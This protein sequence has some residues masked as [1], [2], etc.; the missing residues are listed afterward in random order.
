MA[1]RNQWEQFA[2]NFNTFYDLTGKV[3][4]GMENRKIMDDEVTEGY[5]NEDGL[6]G[7]HRG[8]K[9]FRYG[10]EVYDKQITPEKLRGLRNQ[11]LINVMSKYGDSKGAMEL[12]QSQAT[13]DATT[14]S[15][16]AQVKQNELFA[17]TFDER[18]KSFGLGN[19]LTSS[20]VG[21]TNASKERILATYPLEERKMRAEALGLEWKNKYTEETFNF[22]VN[23][24]KN[25]SEQA[26][27]TTEELEIALNERKETTGNKVLAANSGYE[28]EIQRQ[29]VEKQDLLEKETVNNLMSKYR[30]AAASGAFTDDP[31][32]AKDFIV[33]GLYDVNP[34]LSD[35]LRDNYNKAEIQNITSQSVILKKNAMQAYSTGGI[36]ALSAKID[37]TNGA[38]KTKVVMGG[39][40]KGSMQINQVDD[41]G[42]FVRVIVQGGDEVE[43]LKNL[44]ISLDPASMLATT[45]DYMD[46]AKTE[47]ETAYNKVLK[48][49][50][51]EETKG[52]KNATTKPT[53]ESWAVGLLQKNPND[54]IALAALVGMDLSLDEIETQVAQRTSLDALEAE[55]KAKEKEKPSR[56]D[57]TTTD[58]GVST[59]T[60]VANASGTGN[61]SDELKKAQAIVLQGVP[62]E[63]LAPAY[64]VQYNEALASVES[65]TTPG[66]ITARINDLQAEI[67]ASRNGP[68]P[69]GKVKLRDSNIKVIEEL[70][71][72]LGGLKPSNIAGG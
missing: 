66:G 25:A 35:D 15:T 46:L 24:A 16:A 22:D 38:P 34:A 41:N 69:K 45:K 30:D 40:G 17:A 36:E 72:L 60:T 61:L 20:Q 29:K 26:N 50:K 19:E 65:L 31:D 8:N 54:P 71:K 44:E 58:A 5:S 4:A 48:E 63:N 57:K 49:W 14:A 6:A 10:G 39:Q 47:S 59:V 12:Q 18:Q 55:K 33:N 51:E 62:D 27:L 68:Q 56:Q 67:D 11:R 28:V 42:K 2:D 43:F 64:L 37:E 23:V 3:Q 1:R 7:P 21:L 32:A 13:I 9:E 53:K 70:K 52:L